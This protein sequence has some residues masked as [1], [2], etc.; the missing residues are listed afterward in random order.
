MHANR[1]CTLLTRLMPR[2]PAVCLATAFCL[3]DAQG[4]LVREQVDYAAN[5]DALTAGNGQVWA[6]RYGQTPVTRLLFASGAFVDEAEIALPERTLAAEISPDGVFYAVTI[7][8][9]TGVNPSVSLQ[10]KAR[11][12]AWTTVGQIRAVDYNAK[13]SSAQLVFVNRRLMVNLNTSWSF[14]GGG[15]VIVTDGPPDPALVIFDRDTRNLSF[16]PTGFSIINGT[17]PLYG[18]R[19]EPGPFYIPMDKLATS[20]DGL[21][22]SELNVPVQPMNDVT[23]LLQV[24]AQFPIHV[25]GERLFFREILSSSGIGVVNAGGRQMNYR[26]PFGENGLGAADTTTPAGQRYNFPVL[27]DA[28]FLH[29]GEVFFGLYRQTSQEGGADRHLVAFSGDYLR[30]FDFHVYSDVGYIDGVTEHDACYVLRATAGGTALLRLTSD[31]PRVTVG[32]R[33]KL[34]ASTRTQI[35]YTSLMIYDPVTGEPAAGTTERQVL[36]VEVAPD[37]GAFTVLETSTDLV[38]WTPVGLPFPSGQTATFVLQ[39]GEPRRFFR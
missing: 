11:G 31:S 39:P 18:L 4:A 32:Q 8:T 25:E 29:G 28:L 33:A 21:N 24:G 2:L 23:S 30:N 3:I 7:G 37:D 6:C 36:D 20:T 22:W 13:V 16:G 38:N 34:G 17:G 9:E 5:Y 14:Y 1:S 26:V 15:T 27:D 12:E 35:F 10:E 19:K